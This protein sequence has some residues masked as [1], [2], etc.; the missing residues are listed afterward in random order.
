MAAL[1][2]AMASSA[3]IGD[4]YIEIEPD[5]PP[6]GSSSAVTATIL[7]E[8]IVTSTWTGPYRVSSTG[9]FTVVVP[10]AAAVDWVAAGADAAAPDPVALLELP[11]VPVAPDPIPVDVEPEP[12]PE[13]LDVPDPTV[14]AASS[15]ARKPMTS[16][17]ARA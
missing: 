7:P 4:A 17:I 16:R 8:A 11:V 13:P 2:A 9:P 1:W 3:R 10:P 12:E 5:L 15:G 14:R 6:D